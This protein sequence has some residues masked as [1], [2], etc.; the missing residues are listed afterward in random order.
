MWFVDLAMLVIHEEDLKNI[1]AII[2]YS[3]GVIV[4]R[5]ALG[6]EIS[7]V[8]QAQEIHVPAQDSAYYMTR[9]MPDIAG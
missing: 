1:D 9:N 5:G 3:D 8:L 7:S 6:M 4:A 2:K